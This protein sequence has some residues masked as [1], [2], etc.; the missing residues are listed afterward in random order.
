MRL[1]QRCLKQGGSLIQFSD[2]FSF[3]IVSRFHISRAL[4]VALR[5]VTA[6]ALDRVSD[7]M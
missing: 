6:L 3:A 1:V 5:P 2:Y 4:K 7:G